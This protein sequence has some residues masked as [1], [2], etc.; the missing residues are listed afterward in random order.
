MGLCNV[1]VVSSLLLKSV[2]SK[3]GK[4]CRMLTSENLF[5]YSCACLVICGQLKKKV[6]DMYCE[7]TT[8]VT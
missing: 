8:D 6:G 2:T 7:G 5:L 4:F 1:N 3:R